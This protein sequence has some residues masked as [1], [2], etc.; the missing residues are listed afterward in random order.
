MRWS[1]VRTREIIGASTR[2]SSPS[3]LL[4]ATQLLEW[5]WGG[6]GVVGEGASEAVGERGVRVGV[7]W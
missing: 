4:P 3:F 7:G 1:R 2:D 6:G 5:G